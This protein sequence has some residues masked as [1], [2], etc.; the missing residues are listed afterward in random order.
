MYKNKAQIPIQKT[1]IILGLS[2][3]IF[4]TM[5]LLLFQTT[6]VNI[7]DKKLKTQI[8][9]SKIFN[10]DC[11]SKDY[12]TIEEQYFTQDNLNNNCF[13]NLENDL[14][15]RLSI[16]MGKNY[17][18]ANEE[19]EFTRKKNYCNAPD[20]NI[21]CTRMIYPITYIDTSNKQQST[22]L[23]VEIISSQT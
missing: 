14:N 13:K 3:I 16:D 12:A 22:H 8:V 20:S 19:S 1:L 17:I 7:D 15:L 2:T 9:I 10:S 21:L 5:L 6:K 23:I 4:I 11:F 18:Y